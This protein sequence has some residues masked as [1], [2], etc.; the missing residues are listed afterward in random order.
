MVRFVSMPSFRGPSSNL[1]L[2]RFCG[3]HATLEPDSKHVEANG[4]LPPRRHQSRRP[5]QN[6][7]TSRED[8]DQATKMWSGCGP[9]GAQRNPGGEVFPGTAIPGFRPAACIQA[10]KMWSGCSPDGAQRNPGG[11]GSLYNLP[12]RLVH[13]TARD[14]SPSIRSGTGAFTRS[15][16][17][18]ENRGLS[19]ISPSL[20]VSA[21]SPACRSPARLP[22]PDTVPCRHRPQSSWSAGCPHGPDRTLYP[23]WPTAR[24]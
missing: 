5:P 16:S 24:V 3:I 10:T 2:A 13:A 12:R 18:P 19:P 9:D 21:P 1:R 23:A 8:A 22:K 11:R 15:A 20:K 4:L 17:G 6:R 7:H 14:K